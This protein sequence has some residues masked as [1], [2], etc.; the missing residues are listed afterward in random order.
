MSLF[1][2]LSLYKE[3]K[4]T[5]W[6]KTSVPLINGWSI[7]IKQANDFGN[8]KHLL[9]LYTKWQFIVL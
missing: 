6:I 4:E 7:L 1:Q 3:K 8:R 2:K 5:C 9:T